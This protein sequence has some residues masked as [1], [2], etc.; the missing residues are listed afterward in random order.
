EI[1]LQGVLASPLRA[2][3]R[4]IGTLGLWRRGGGGA[5]ST[6]DQNFAQE[7]ADR[8]ALAI[9]SARLVE[10]L[11]AEVEERKENEENLRVTAELLQ[12]ADQQRKAL[13]ENLVSAQEE[14][15]RRIAIDVHDDS[16]QA[17]AAISLRLQILRRHALSHAAAQGIAEIEDAVMKSI[18]RLRNLLIRLEA[19]SLDKE[20][21]AHA[22]DRCI[23]D[24]FPDSSP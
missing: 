21:L 13:M 1:D 11:R 9:E 3:G 8:A 4:V 17:M 6:R 14:E 24:L 23:E 20:G 10:R 15:R 5:H 2:H 7:L 16:I 12:Q 18:A 22:I 19:T